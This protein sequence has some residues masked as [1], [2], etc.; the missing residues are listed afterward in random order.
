MKKVWLVAAMWLMACGPTD[1]GYELALEQVTAPT[2]EVDELVR[3]KML[4]GT[5]ALALVDIEVQMQIAGQQLNLMQF[6]L[7]EDLDGDMKF[8][9]GDALTVKEPVN[10]YGPD[11]IGKEFII[12]LVRKEEGN[13]VTIL[14]EQV[15]Q[16]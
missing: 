2:E 10:L 8:G 3:L 11:S 16:P 4:E 7:T 12:K 14:D 5:E 13:I 6:E 9:V 15:W 1:S